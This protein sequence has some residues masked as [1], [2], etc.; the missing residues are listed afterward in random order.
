[1]RSRDKLNKALNEG[2]DFKMGDYISR[3]WDIYK[4]QAGYYIL[5]A[6][7]YL[8]ISGVAG[9]IPLIGPLMVA[10]PLSVGYWIYSYAIAKK[11][12]PDFAMFFQGFKNFG[13]Q[14]GV[15]FFS[16]LFAMILLIPVVIK[17]VLIF[18]Q[19]LPELIL[20]AEYGDYSDDPF[21]IIDMFLSLFPTW[22]WVMLFVGMLVAF[23]IS[24][25]YRMAY[26]FVHFYEMG[27]WEAMETSRKLLQ[28]KIFAAMGLMLI[29]AIF[30]GIGIILCYIGI[31][32]TL[33]LQFTIWYA[34]FADITGLEEED[35]VDDQP[36]MTDHLIINN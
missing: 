31:L 6:L 32:L 30:S 36:D 16:S 19:D 18:I 33:P 10:G 28:K 2:Y 11:Q 13:Q 24:T 7:L 9:Y 27:F 22:F 23:I 4:Q 20:Q 21:A 35:K 14:L 15:T 5:F 29:A 17:L 26:G 25:L 1:M 3:G 34:A 12:T 8:M